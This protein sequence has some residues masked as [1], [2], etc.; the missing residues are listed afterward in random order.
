VLALTDAL[1][2]HGR[3]SWDKESGYQRV[4]EAAAKALAKIG[5]KESVPGLLMVLEECSDKVP[6]SYSLKDVIQS[7]L[8][9]AGD[10][11]AVPG[12]LAELERTESTTAG[13]GAVIALGEIGDA[14]AIPALVRYVKRNKYASSWSANDNLR[15]AVQ[16]LTNIGTPEA[17]AAAKKY[18]RRLY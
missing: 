1:S 4:Y 6:F 7:A 13:R 9:K 18:R 5:G 11:R 14:S 16:A 8:G 10:V 3:G 12:L 15:C 2:A 17:L